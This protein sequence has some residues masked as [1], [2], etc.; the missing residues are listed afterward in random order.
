MK[1][2]FWRR[3]EELFHAALERM[4]DARRSF[5][6]EACGGDTELRRQVEML[7]SLDENAGSLLEKPALADFALTPAAGGSLSPGTRLGPY[8]ILSLLGAGG[9]GEVW[10]ARDTR[11]NRLVAIKTSHARFTERFE[12]EARVIAALNHPHICSIY[13]VATS[14]DGFSYLVMEYVEGKPLHGPVPIEEA[15]RLAGQILDAIDAAHSKE[16]THR[17]LK[18]SNILVGNNGAKVLDFGLAKIESEAG[19]QTAL[20]GEGAI[21]GTLQYMA[22]EQIEGREADAR[23]DIFA[24]G[25]VLYELITGKRAF[26]GASRASLIASILKD[27]PRPV[28]ELQPL[29]PPGLERVLETCLEKDPDKRWQSAREAK[30]VLEWIAAEAPPAAIEARPAMR[31]RQGLAA[32]VA[33]ISVGL[34]VWAV[35]F[36]PQSSTQVSRFQMVLP[37]NVTFRYYLSVS[38]D[39]R[40]LVFSATGKDGLW[41]R[42]FSTLDWRRLPGTEGALGPFWS[43]DSRYVAF[44]VQNQIMKINVAGGPPQTLCTVP[45]TAANPAMTSAG[46]GDWNRDGVIIFGSSGTNSGGPL[47]KVS[48]AG[49]AAT[50]VTAVDGKK[51]DLYHWAPAFLPDGKHYIYLRSGAPEVRGIYS[52]S[53]DAKPEDQSRERLL[54]TSSPASYANGYLFFNLQGA[55]MAQPFDAERLR[56]NGEPVPLAEGVDIAWFSLGAFSVSPSGV[57]AYRGGTLGGS[58][59]FTWFD[60]KGKILSTFGQPGTDST[61]HLSPDGTRGLVRDAAL[62]GPADL[63][64]LDLSSGRRTRLT[65]HHNVM[66]DGVWSPDGSRIAFAGG[67][68]MDTIYEEPSSGAGDEK[69]L[70]KEPRIGH[71]PTSWSPDGRFLL[72]NTVNAVRTGYDLWVLPLAKDA[73]GERKPVL[74]L[75]AVFNEWGARFSPDG[76]WIAYVTNETG[77]REIFVRSFI[78]S[79]PSGVPAVGEGKWQITK[80]GGNY[81]KW[82]ADGKEL[83]YDDFPESYVKTAVEVNANG[84]VFEFGT[85]QRLFPGPMDF[86]GWD[87]TPDGQRFLSSAPQVQQPS[88][89]ITIVL[90][91]PALLKK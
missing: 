15:L 62:G 83:I 43:P 89:P 88:L 2:E 26:T 29:T 13:D 84:S 28:H 41:I 73:A 49:G 70:F 11:L 21:L 86:G 54:A 19:T 12:R 24:F 4:P 38:P 60:R 77:H 72:Y 6:D 37:E 82:R 14:S 34:A 44:D 74:L 9:M 53:L 50:A 80:D 71:E 61:V 69:E 57:L 91:W 75:G 67:D 1:Q 32:L 18:P 68:D 45:G 20:T 47:W 63:W 58:R 5:L 51:G 22:P 87:V 10:K 81:P 23:S 66:L 90:N 8:E 65:F 48:Q 16:I 85:P 17:D 40:K 52:G 36:R 33:L 35:W 64:T 78:A 59:Q 46:S 30:H 39:G 76:H 25:L 27:Q 31:V 79:G 56:L 7:V 3:A 55:L 42:D